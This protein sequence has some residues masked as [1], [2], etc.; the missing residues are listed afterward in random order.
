M[1]RWLR[2]L[3]DLGLLSSETPRFSRQFVPL[4]VVATRTRGVQVANEE[5]RTKNRWQY[6]REYCIGF[7]RLIALDESRIN[8]RLLDYTGFLVL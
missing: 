6:G 2:Q 3:L 7:S 8:N 1:N 4:M 5:S